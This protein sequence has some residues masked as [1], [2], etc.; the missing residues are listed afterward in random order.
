GGDLECG[1]RVVVE[2]ADEA[3]VFFIL[4]SAEVQLFFQL[5]KCSRQASQRWSEMRGSFSMMGCSSG[6]FES[7]TRSGLVSMRRCES[8]PSWAFTF[9]NSARSSSTYRGRQFLSPI[10][11]T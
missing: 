1:A 2:A 9:C 3:P 7:R 6:S 10:E 11:F 8:A 5:A 4:Y